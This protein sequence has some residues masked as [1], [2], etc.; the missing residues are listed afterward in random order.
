MV[1]RCE[2][3]AETTVVV[4]EEAW[5]E[6]AV[7]VVGEE[8]AWAEVAVTEEVLGEIAVMVPESSFGGS[9]ALWLE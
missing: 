8:E 4:E 7:E 1:H 2:G 5:A 9:E 3:M 6:V